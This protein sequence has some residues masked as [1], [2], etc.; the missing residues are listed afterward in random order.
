MVKIALYTRVSTRDKQDVTKQRDY[1]IN[2]L[3]LKNQR[4]GEEKWELFDI[5]VDKGISGTKAKRPAL[6]DM[7]KD[8]NKFDVVLVYKLD[9]IGRSMKHLFTLMEI[10]KEKNVQFV[11][12]TQSI[13]TTTPEGKLFF[14]ILAAMAEFEAEV[15]R[16]RIKDGLAAARARGKKLGRKKGQKDRKPRSKVGYYLRHERERNKIPRSKHEQLLEG[17]KNDRK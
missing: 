9:R 16:M 7:L 13:D 12:A 6:D 14:N 2:F 15:T 1:L 17:I 10:F 4:E 8:I 11:S 3:N 5:Y